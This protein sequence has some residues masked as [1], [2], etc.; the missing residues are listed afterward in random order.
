MNQ[1]IRRSIQQLV[2]AGTSATF[3]ASALGGVGVQSPPPGPGQVPDYFGV[4]P[5]YATSPQPVL[6][7]VT[8]TDTGGGT[9]AVAAAST[10][11]Y[12]NWVRT[13]KIMDVQVLNGGSGY[14]AATTTVTVTGGS[15]AALTLTPIVNSGVITGF[16]QIP[17]PLPAGWAG[18]G[19]GF[20]TPIANTGIRKFV[21]SLPH[22]FANNGLGQNLPIAASSTPVA[23][24]DYY[25]IAVVEYS[26]KMHS[27]LP[28]TRLRGYVQLDPA[29][30]AT[31][32]TPQYLG[33][34]IVAQKDRPVRIKLV[35]RLPTGAAGNHPFPVDHT[36][37]G[38]SGGTDT[39]N[40][41]A[42]HLHGGNTPWISDGLPRQW[43]KPAGETGPNRGES[44]RDIPDMWFDS[45]LPRADGSYPVI[46]SC[47]GQMT[48]SNTGA[49]NNPGPGALS[50]Y[51]TNQ[52]S[53][54][55]MMYHDHAEGITRLNVYGGQAAGY[56]LRDST[57]AA[58]E[59]DATTNPTGVLPPLTDNIP[60]VI[61]EKTFVPPN[62][63]AYPVLNYYGPFAS[64]LTSQDPTW[65]WGTGAP[66][67]VVPGTQGPGDLWVPHVYM[68]NQNPGDAG[69]ANP[70]GR[71]DYG[72]W[73]WPPFAGT[74]HGEIPNPY[75]DASCNT[76]SGTN[77]N[78]LLGTC[79]GPTIPGMPNGA[80]AVYAAGDPMSQP[81]GGPEAF[82]DTMTVNG[83]VY[84][85]LEVKPKK[86]R[87]RILSVGN[88]RHVNLSLVVASSKS[89]DTTAAANA[90][91]TKQVASDNT[92]DG[93]HL[94]AAN[95][96]DCTEVRMVPW[97]SSQN[98]VSHF[99]AWWYTQQKGGVTFDGRPSGVFDPAVRGPAMVQIGTEGGFLSSPV[100]VKNQ[101][102]NYEYNVKNIVIGNVK[103]HA[104]LL[105]PAERADV[106]VDFSQF[107]GSTI[108]LYN[109]APAALPAGDLRLDYYTGN[110]DNTDTGGAF[111]TLPGYG[112]NS[113]T[114]MQFRVAADCTGDTGCGTGINRTPT[115]VHT[116]D[117]VD[118]THLASLT[119]AVRTAFRDSQE[120]IIVPQ[121][122]YNPVYG[123]TVS[124]VAGG[125][126]SRIS[127]TTL[128]F[129]P[130]PATAATAAVTLDLQ[131]KSIIED[132]TVDYGRMNAML[133][134]EVPKTTAIN[135]TSIPQG[136]I[137]PATEL[138][139]LSQIG[140]PVSGTLAD[141]TQ[142]WKI[143]HNGVDTHPIHFHLF[144]VQIIN[145]VGWDGAISPPQGNELG[146]KDTVRM[147]PLED[148]IVALRP[149]TMTL[150]FKMGNSHRKLD[151]SNPNVAIDTSMSFNL[152][153]TS[154]NAS[155][156]TNVM[157]N[158]GWEYVWHCH[159]LGHEEN[160]FMRS[161][162]VAAQP[163]APAAISATGAATSVAVSWNDNSVVSNWVE[164]Q[165]ATDAAFTANLATFN[166]VQA[167]CANQAGCAR[168]Y[169]DN[170]APANTSVYYRVRS[171]NTVGA[172][173]GV[174]E[175]GF[176][177][178]TGAYLQTIAPELA[179]LTPQFAGYGN[180]TS[181]S[182][183]S[184]TVSRLFV[185]V[186]A[187]SPLSVTFANQAVNTTSAPTTVTLTN[188]GNGILAITG[189]AT[190]G[191]PFARSGGTCPAAFPASLAPGSCTITVTFAP[192]SAVPSSGSLTV[193]DNSN[194]V[195]GSTQVVALTGTGILAAPAAATRLRLADLTGN[196]QVRV[197]W[198]NPAGS[199]ATS[200]AV[201][202]CPGTCTAAGPW[203]TLA[204]ALVPTVATYT[205]NAAN[206]NAPVGGNTYTYQIREINAGGSTASAVSTVRLNNNATA[207]PSSLVATAG[208]TGTK[209][210]TLTYNDNTATE[211][212]FVV[213]WALTNAFNAPFSVTITGSSVNLF[214]L[215]QAN[216]GNFLAQLAWALP[217]TKYI[218]V[219][220]SGNTTAWSNTVSVT[221]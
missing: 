12:A 221:P 81:S 163:E 6:T 94:V 87:L 136:Y 10:Y 82:N 140:T 200:I 211:T 202:R 80:N 192:T 158:Y 103:E 129:K 100:T 106:I 85:Y 107:A 148:A 150:P 109:D 122:A 190:S 177:A 119:T 76:T 120:P 27:D 215:N 208:G 168:S 108:L 180:V 29:T 3:I 151:P 64:Q 75:Y 204:S 155:N 95:A 125:D 128:T 78:T 33:P 220:P 214:N 69:G 176:D 66:G 159:I 93:A 137:D 187:L 142:I 88:D 185:P 40:R 205:N 145:R 121:A 99:P 189:I 4:T 28:P 146:W 160:D 48:C 46:L 112:P 104:L 173:N 19:S 201:D 55:L 57:E 83:T 52:Q 164:I 8:I 152:D 34:V 7:T 59:Y 41:V 92:C 73:F 141:G 39:D 198:A 212:G 219:R 49:T 143:T 111:T 123:T 90:G 24:S 186:A 36:Y 179:S 181:N 63:P 37:M 210:A 118:A 182:A 132:F 31:I 154:G 61:Q 127:D 68:P 15:G 115:N 165:R 43:V 53:Q 175:G 216:A 209:P 62:D 11:D 56:V 184:N 21:D 14:N 167:E 65:R 70:L 96:A 134:V 97:D 171:N 191:A 22:L 58:M 206:G 60:L 23:T 138:V 20:N 113:R 162:A 84:P 139:K 170:T 131:P 2:L 13:D 116:P 172:G 194:G 197:D 124:D 199:T 26:Q 133:G 16:V 79:E 126:L 44:A 38:A 35:N 114:V 18:L 153:P 195:A 89:V 45:A 25:E 166:V 144:H 207:A 130:L 105:G 188:S 17:N 213:Q 9:G 193:T 74:L 161:I 54:R 47:M 169:V 50:F 5:N 149:K 178:A 174:L 1:R 156:V 51:Y 217:G 98:S 218:R 117:D 101:P 86:Y 110:F 67:A 147:N 71:W 91:A 30:G 32:G 157:A 102:V 135:Q 72:P 203:T 42:L 77:V 183:W 196:N